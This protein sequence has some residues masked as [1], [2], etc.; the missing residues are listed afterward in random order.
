MAAAWRTDYT[1]ESRSRKT[2]K[3]R[4]TKTGMITVASAGQTWYVSESKESETTP[5]LLS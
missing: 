1:G 2:S 5:R 4:C 3:G